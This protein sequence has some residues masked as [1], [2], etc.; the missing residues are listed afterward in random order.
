MTPALFYLFKIALVIRDLFYKNFMIV[1]PISEK[2][3]SL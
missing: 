3:K 1:F 2:N